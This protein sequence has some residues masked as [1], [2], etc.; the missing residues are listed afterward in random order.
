MLGD[1]FLLSREVVVGS[2]GEKGTER[3]RG[4]KKG[5]EQNLFPKLGVDA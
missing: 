3:G 4:H 2:G 5:C 1:G